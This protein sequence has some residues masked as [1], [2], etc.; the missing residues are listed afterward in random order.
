MAQDRLAGA[1]AG[2]PA[3]AT[4]ME[5]VTGALDAI[6]VMFQENPERLPPAARHLV[7]GGDRIDVGYGGPVR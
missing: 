5:A 1:V 7:T 6:G 4:P 2:A 3:S